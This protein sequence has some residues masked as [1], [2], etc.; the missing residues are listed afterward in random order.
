MSRASAINFGFQKRGVWEKKKFV[1]GCSALT[2]APYIF[3]TPVCLFVCLFFYWKVLYHL[4]TVFSLDMSGC[5]WISSVRV[6]IS[7]KKNIRWSEI[8]L[9]S[10]VYFVRDVIGLENWRHPFSQ[11]D[12]SR[13][14]RKLIA[15]VVPRLGY[16]ACIFLEFSLATLLVTSWENFPHCIVETPASLSSNLARR[17]SRPL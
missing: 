15:C 6:N 7:A 3:C 16:L 10:L 14:N 1:L 9:V 12:A 4:R 11:S 8:A 5:Q 2:L 17:N 13:T